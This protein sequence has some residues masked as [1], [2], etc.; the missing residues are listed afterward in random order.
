VRQRASTGSSTGGLGS[1]FG[2]GTS[3]ASLFG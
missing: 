1:L 3:I 2:V